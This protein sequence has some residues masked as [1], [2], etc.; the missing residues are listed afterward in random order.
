[1]KILKC[2][3]HDVKVTYIPSEYSLMSINDQ[4]PRSLVVLLRRISSTAG[5]KKNLVCVFWWTGPSTA[6]ATG[7]VVTA[8]EELEEEVAVV[9]DGSGFFEQGLL[10]PR[11]SLENGAFGENGVCSRGQGNGAPI[12]RGCSTQFA[13]VL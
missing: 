2:I 8:C 1:M 5:T 9:S 3:R 13:Y 11:K 4:L 12:R 7:E 6:S 10:P